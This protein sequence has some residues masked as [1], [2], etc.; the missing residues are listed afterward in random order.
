V[1]V[2]IPRIADT[3]DEL[4]WMD[5]RSDVA[6]H[7]RQGTPGWDSH[8]DISLDERAQAVVAWWDMMGSSAPPPMFPRLLRYTIRNAGFRCEAYNPPSSELQIPRRDNTACVSIR[9]KLTELQAAARLVQHAGNCR[10][11]AAILENAET[12]VW[13]TSLILFWRD[14]SFEE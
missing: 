13:D 10:D 14:I 12:A 5:D 8:Y 2:A 4:D 9:T 7:C 3:E 1:H 6:R 11:A